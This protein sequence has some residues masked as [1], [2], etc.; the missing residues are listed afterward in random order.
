MLFVDDRQ[1]QRLEVDVLLNERM[2]ANEHLSGAG[3]Q[4]AQYAPSFG[5]TRPAGEEFDADSDFAQGL[6]RHPCVL[7]GEQLGRSHNRGLRARLRHGS[8][9]TQ[10]DRGLAAAD[11][12]LQK[13]LHGHGTRQVRGNFGEGT[14]LCRS[15]G[16]PE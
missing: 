14:A 3:S 1:R 10:S 11:V 7:F 16:E 13:T 15:Q 5:S 6:E 2:G 9:R 4:L 8:H 12:A